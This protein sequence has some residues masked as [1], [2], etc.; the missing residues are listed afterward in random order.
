M[1][2]LLTTTSIVS[3]GCRYTHAFAFA[4]F[5]I[6]ESSISS[7]RDIS[8]LNLLA[9]IFSLSALFD[10]YLSPS[11]SMFGFTVHSTV[12]DVPFAV[13]NVTS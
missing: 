3:F 8:I 12:T 6:V 13:E 5:M 1:S 4:Y 7:A 10:L 2:V 9:S 11:L